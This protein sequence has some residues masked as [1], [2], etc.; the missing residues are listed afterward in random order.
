MKTID[1]ND[2][3]NRVKSHGLWSV[4]FLVL[5][6][7][8]A[9]TAN[10]DSE[11]SA[12]DSDDATS[13]V[14][15]DA[16]QDDAEDVGMTALVSETSDGGKIYTSDDRFKCAVVTHTGD[17]TAG[18][19]RID[20]GDGCKDDRGRTRR[21]AI[22]VTYAGPWKEAGSTW[23]LTFDKYFVN[24]INLAGTRKVVNITTDTLRRRFQVDMEDG[25]ATWP[26]GRIARR[27]VH[28]IREHERNTSN[29]LMRLIIYG[30]AEGNHRNGR[31]YQIEIL[32]PL[33]YSRECAA[34]GVFIPV[35]G[36]KL[37]KHGNR[38]ITVD[39]GDGTCDNVVTL[40]NVNGRKKD[41]RVIGG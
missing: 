10:E 27:R 32:E 12:E 6:L 40:I 37:I 14:M 11:F 2:K 29:I 13:D 31:G 18:T 33:V 23:E 1:G 5:V 20:F 30:T 7:L 16:S 34:E 9:C 3:Q 22:V 4:F 38:Q 26:D 39:Y 25:M 17:K 35:S 19:I 24:D 21:G 28:H 8:G 41:I 15:D 36:V